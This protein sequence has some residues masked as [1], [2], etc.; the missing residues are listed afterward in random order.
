[1]VWGAGVG[2]GLAA[3]SLGLSRVT[4]RR[5]SPSPAPS[6]R[7]SPTLTPLPRKPSFSQRHRAEVREEKRVPLTERG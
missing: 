3:E 5:S 4:C 7:I 1:M 6:Q 2:G